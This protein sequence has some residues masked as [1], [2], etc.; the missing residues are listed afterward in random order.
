MENKKLNAGV[1]DSENY[2]HEDSHILKEKITLLKDLKRHNKNISIL[3][4]IN[5]AVKKVRDKIGPYIYRKR[6]STILEIRDIFVNKDGSKYYGQW[7][8][9][10]N[11][12]EGVGIIVKPDGS[13]Y[14]GYWKNDQMNQKGRIIHFRG[15]YYI[16]NHE[17]INFKIFIRLKL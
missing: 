16:I 12:K 4:G 3:D 6:A 15:D 11:K 8:P 17:N 7:N 9:N 2:E 1:V 14:E 5:E 10:N 13:I